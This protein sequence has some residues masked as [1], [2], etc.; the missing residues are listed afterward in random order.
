MAKTYYQASWIGRNGVR[1]YSDVETAGDRARMQAPLDV[2][3]FELHQ[4]EADGLRDLKRRRSTPGLGVA[5]ALHNPTPRA[6]R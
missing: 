1:V 2:T 6:Q 3:G 5:V 4:A